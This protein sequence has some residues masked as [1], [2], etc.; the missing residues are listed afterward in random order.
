LY[1]YRLWILNTLLLLILV[2]S[3]LGRRVE[4][5]SVAHSDFLRD[6]NLPYRDWKTTDIALSASDLTILQPDATLV[7]QYVGPKG[8]WAELAIIAGHRKK[9][10]HTP[11]FCMTGGGWTTE[12]QQSCLITVPGRTL[13]GMKMRMIK[14]RDQ[15]LVIYFFTD[16]AYSTSNLVQF[17]ASQ[18]LKRFG[19]EVPLGALVRVTVPVGSDAAAAESLCTDFAQATLPG[20]LQTLRQTHL[21]VQ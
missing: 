18:M 11:A 12:T 9:S 13:S 21:N 7:R 17:Q 8:Q 14:E 3:H 10:I 1:R 4:S 16:G 6:L 2:G 19:A 5:A 15:L 20:V